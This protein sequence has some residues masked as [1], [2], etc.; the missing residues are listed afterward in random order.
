MRLAEDLSAGL[1]LCDEI[2]VPLLSWNG[3][4][5]VLKVFADFAPAFSTD[6]GSSCLHLA[7]DTSRRAF[8]FGFPVSR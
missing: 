6:S 1:N 5:A 8:R 7:V 3:M 4:I 2:Q